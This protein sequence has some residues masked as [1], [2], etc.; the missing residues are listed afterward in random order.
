MTD[1]P[2]NLDL[3]TLVA[4][5]DKELPPAQSAAV[6]AAIIDDAAAR[7]TVRLLRLSS[8][9]VAYAFD[10]VLDEPVPGRL[11]LLAEAG[12]APGAAT[13]PVRR[14]RTLARRLLPL[15]ASLAALGIGLAAG[16]EIRDAGLTLWGSGGRGYVPAAAPAADPFAASFEST[17]LTALDSGAPGRVFTYAGRPGESGRIELGRRLATGFGATCR[18]SKRQESRGGTAS[19][20]AG[21]ACRDPEH[22]WSVLLLPGTGS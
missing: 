11:R 3:E 14:P 12:P 10:Q 18:E 16:F 5:V 7:E 21:L 19:A 2:L 4:Y 15:A 6:E 1:K 20:A 9:A 17:L 13:A 22:D 8:A